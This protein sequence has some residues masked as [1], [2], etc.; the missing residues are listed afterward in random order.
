[1]KRNHWILL[2]LFLVL[3]GRSPTTLGA[4]GPHHGPLERPALEP[5]HPV[6]GKTGHVTIKTNMD[7]T[8]PI[9]MYVTDVS[10]AEAMETLATVTESRWRLA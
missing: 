8:Q 5:G 7:L 6:R 4:L 9:K 3:T 1:M 10:L 2:A